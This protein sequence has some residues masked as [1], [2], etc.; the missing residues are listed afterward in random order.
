MAT[1]YS[2]GYGYFGCVYLLQVCKNDDEKRCFM[3]KFG[4]IGILIIFASLDLTRK[5][6]SAFFLHS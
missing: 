6:F 4:F 5:P 2:T 1:K 3:K